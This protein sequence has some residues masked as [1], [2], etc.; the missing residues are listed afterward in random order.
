MFYEGIIKGSQISYYCGVKYIKLKIYEIKIKYFDIPEFI[1]P[2]H[3][4]KRNQMLLL[5]CY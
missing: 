2:I 5:M 3:S 4:V 1:F